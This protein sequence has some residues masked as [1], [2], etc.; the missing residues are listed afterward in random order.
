MDDCIFCKIVTGDIP[1]IKIYEDDHVFAFMDINPVSEGHALVIPK[2]H[3]ENLW[4]ISEAS[5]SAVH[6]ASKT[7]VHGMKKAMG[8]VSVA[9]IQ[10]NGKGVNQIVMH[11]HLHLIPRASDG[12]ALKLT[13]WEMIPGDMDAINRTGAAIAAAVEND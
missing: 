4:E 6:T 8:P 10:L 7:I 13:A 9:A 5:L 12:E 1:S 11:Y 2:I 3:A